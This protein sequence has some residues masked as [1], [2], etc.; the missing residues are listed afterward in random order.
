MTVNPTF[1]QPDT[2]VGQRDIYFSSEGLF[3]Y[4]PDI[5]VPII[6]DENMN[7]FVRANLGAQGFANFQLSFNN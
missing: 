1:A 4:Q 5:V 3:D 2:Y 7:A 6:I